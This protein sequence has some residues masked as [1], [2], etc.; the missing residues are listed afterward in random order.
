MLRQLPF[1]K[2]YLLVGGAI[3]LLLLGYQLAFKKPI[4]AWKLNHSLKQQL[5][6]SADISSEPQYE[7]RK[8]INLGRVI[9]LYRADTSEFRGNIISK[10]SSIAEEEKVKLTEV[11]TR[12][13]LYHTYQVIIQKL[14]FEGDYFSLVK[15]LN[16]IQAA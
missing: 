13:P 10:I 1:K 6:H 14:N 5:L 8:N 9:D 16:R 3:V 4:E 12:D 7:E 11:P 2:E 15:I